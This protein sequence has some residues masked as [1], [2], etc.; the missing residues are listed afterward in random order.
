[1]LV[2]RVTDMKA[3]KKSREEIIKQYKL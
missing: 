1:L 3:E 2:R